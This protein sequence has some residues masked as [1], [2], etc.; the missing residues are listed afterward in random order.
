MEKVHLLLDEYFRAGGWSR[1][2]VPTR[3]TLDQAGLADVADQL[4]EV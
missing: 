4:E 3:E 1:D 2:G